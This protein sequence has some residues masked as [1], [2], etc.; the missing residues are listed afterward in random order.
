MSAEI[1]GASAVGAKRTL[2]LIPA[3]EDL[4]LVDYVSILPLD[5]GVS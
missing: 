1:S 5:G 2:S 4:W 3:N